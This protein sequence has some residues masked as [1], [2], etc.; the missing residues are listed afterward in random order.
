M[1]PV[2]LDCRGDAAKVW[3]RVAET[4]PHEQPNG[5]TAQIVEETL[6]CYQRSLRRYGNLE[7]D[8]ACCGQLTELQPLKTGGAQ[9]GLRVDVWRLR[10]HHQVATDDRA[11]NG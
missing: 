4:V 3:R 10:P 9:R 6:R 8:A 2:L 7:P 5:N 11:A 1:G